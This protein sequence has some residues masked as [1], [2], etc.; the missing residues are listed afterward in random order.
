VLLVIFPIFIS[1]HKLLAAYKLQKFTA[2]FLLKET[3]VLGLTGLLHVLP[4]PLYLSYASSTFCSLPSPSPYCSSVF[5]NIYNF[6]QS[7]FWY[8]LF[9]NV[10]LFRYWELKQIP[11]FL[12]A[13]PMMYISLSAIYN[14]IRLDPKRA[15]SFSTSSSVVPFNTFFAN[16]VLVPFILYWA[17]NLLII[18]FIANVQIITRLFASFPIVYW[19]MGERILEGDKWCVLYFL[20]YICVGS[21]LFSNFY[22]WT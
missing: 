6:V 5:P 21:I 3:L 7:Q 4:I 17:V 19:Y 10:G 16:P 8:S 1:C 22:P 20:V 15:L 9:R 12:L 2:S 14:Y 11:N 18:V 13:L